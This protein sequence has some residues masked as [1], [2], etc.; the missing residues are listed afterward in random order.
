[1]PTILTISTI[2]SGSIADRNSSQMYKS[3]ESKVKHA[4]AKNRNKEHN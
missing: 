4:M 2:M 3:K 1:M